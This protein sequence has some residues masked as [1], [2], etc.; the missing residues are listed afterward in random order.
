EMLEG[1]GDLIN[2][3]HAGSHGSSANQDDDL[4][5][6]DAV[7]AMTLDGV[8]G[9]AFGQEDAGRTELAIDAVGIDNARIDRGTLDDRAF[10]R[11]IAAGKR[12]RRS[13]TALTS[14]LRAHDDV[15]GMDAIFV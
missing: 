9:G 11:Q 3:L 15:I 1:G 2:L 7:V 5:G 4:A 14:K 6:L 13:Q 12:D 10:R 8:N